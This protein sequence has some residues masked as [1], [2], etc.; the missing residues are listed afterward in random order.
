[1]KTILFSFV[2]CALLVSL[3]FAYP[4]DLLSSR[5]INGAAATVN[6]F[7]WHAQITGYLRNNQTTLCGGALVSPTHVLTAAHCV[8]SNE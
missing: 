6:Q 7:P 5:I 8:I 3:G 1:M 2:S 4:E